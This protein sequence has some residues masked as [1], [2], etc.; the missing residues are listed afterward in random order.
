MEDMGPLIG[1]TFLQAAMWGLEVFYFN[2]WISF[3]EVYSFCVK[4]FDNKP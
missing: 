4:C 1:L 3:G 2:H